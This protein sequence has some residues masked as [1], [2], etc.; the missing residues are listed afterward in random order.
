MKLSCLRANSIIAEKSE[1]LAQTWPDCEAGYSPQ[2]EDCWEKPLSSKTISSP[3]LPQ[4][5]KNPNETSS[6]VS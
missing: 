5:L 4:S 2:I 1:I 6:V 3:A